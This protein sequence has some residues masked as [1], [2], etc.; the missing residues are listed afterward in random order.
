MKKVIVVFLIAFAGLLSLLT[1][2]QGQPTPGPN[3][4]QPTPIAGFDGVTPI[5]PFRALS[6]A[7]TYPAAGTV[8]PS[9]GAQ[10]A[11]KGPRWSAVSNP[12]VSTQAT[13]SKAAVAAMR[14]VADCISFSAGSTTAIGAAG[15]LTINLRDGATGAGTVIWTHEIALAAAA[16]QNV[17]PFGLC[18]LNLAGTT[19]TAMTFE[20]SA[21][22]TNLIESVSISGYDIQ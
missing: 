13:A 6:L 12:A 16:G 10:I 14:H 19:N 7:N 11:E 1:Y 20:F 15:F 17:P 8:F 5:A 22:T 21:L 18:G 4:A 9:L 2:L 3:L